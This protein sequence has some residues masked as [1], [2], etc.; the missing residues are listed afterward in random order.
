MDETVAY[1]RID[2]EFDLSTEEGR[3]KLN[4][5]VHVLRDEVVPPAGRAQ[6]LE[7]GRSVV[8]ALIMDF[9]GTAGLARAVAGSGATAKQIA[10]A[11]R[12]IQRHAAPLGRGER[13]AI[14]AD[15]QERY[16]RLLSPQDRQRLERLNVR[17]LPRGALYMR[18]A[19]H[20][21]LSA[22]VEERVMPSRDFHKVIPSRDDRIIRRAL[23]DPMRGFAE[24]YGIPIEWGSDPEEPIV[25]VEVF[26]EEARD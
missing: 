20:F 22:R 26:W 3:E 11:Q 5:A 8:L 1:T 6:R 7:I 14:G 10:A 15:Y 13:R 2:G 16:R 23:N 19:G 25:H 4:R 21:I 24:S 9:N 17:K 18:F 12:Q